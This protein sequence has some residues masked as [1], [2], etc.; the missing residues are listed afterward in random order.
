MDEQTV[1]SFICVAVAIHTALSLYIFLRAKRTEQNNSLLHRELFGIMKKIEGLS[2]GRRT[3][4]SAQI[5][6]VLERLSYQLPSRI[7]ARAGE[8]IYDT[9][10]QVLKTL[11]AIAPDIQEHPEAKDRVNSLV[12]SMERLE[13]TIVTLTQ[14]SVR[15]AILDTKNALIEEQRTLDI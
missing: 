4:I 8:A 11:A 1:F 3:L 13:T 10:S 7:S 5:D 2:A 6:T 14:E 9:E 12:S 15:Q